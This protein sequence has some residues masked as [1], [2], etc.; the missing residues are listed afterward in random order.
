VACVVIAFI[1]LPSICCKVSGPMMKPKDSWETI[2]EK[3]RKKEL[4]KQAMLGKK[5]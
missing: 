4:E 2:I 3:H 5:K 1:V